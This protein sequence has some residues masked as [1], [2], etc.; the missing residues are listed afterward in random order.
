LESTKL[1]VA[2]AFSFPVAIFRCG[3][4]FIRH[5][6]AGQPDGNRERRQ[7]SQP[8]TG[9][10]LRLRTQQGG[11]LPRKNEIKLAAEDQFKIEAR[12]EIVVGRLAKRNISFRNL[13]K[14]GPDV[15]PLGHARQV[16]KI[17]QGMETTAVKHITG[18]IRDGKFKATPSASLARAGTNFKPSS[19]R[20]A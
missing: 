16:I 3:D 5:C 6:F 19:R 20:C 14:A 10:P 9:Q 7:P 4:A 8:G 2:F 13:E 1:V 15:S 18:I 17:K 11:H 12:A